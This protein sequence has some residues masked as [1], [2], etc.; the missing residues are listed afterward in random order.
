[1]WQVRY[2]DEVFEVLQILAAF[3]ELGESDWRR[4]IAEWVRFLYVTTTT[5]DGNKV[6]LLSEH[7][8]K[9]VAVTLED[10]AREAVV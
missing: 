8:E 9:A 4:E 6:R 10:V 3:V 7:A 5:K 2:G 1:M